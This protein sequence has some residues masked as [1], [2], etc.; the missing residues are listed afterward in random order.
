MS[1]A[2]E[3]KIVFNCPKCS[4]EIATAKKNAGMQVICAHCDELIS[5]PR[6]GGE[7]QFVGEMKIALGQVSSRSF[8]LNFDL[9]V[10]SN[11]EGYVQSY[12]SDKKN[13]LVL[14]LFGEAQLREMKEV[15]KNLD[16]MME[17]LT[18]SGQMK[19][20]RLCLEEWICQT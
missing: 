20:K 18:A 4:K 15:F 6:E 14:L 17:R 11:G 13:K 1:D 10:K 2:Q 9:I 8:I 3:S 5:I 7:K 12:A 19:K 16:E